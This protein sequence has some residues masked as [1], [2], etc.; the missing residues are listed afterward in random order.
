MILARSKD[1]LT[2]IKRFEKQQNGNKTKWTD[3][4]D[5]QGRHLTITEEGTIHIFEEVEDLP[6]LGGTFTKKPK[7]KLTKQLWLATD[8]FMP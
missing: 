2:V 4:K 1:E 5:I 3:K 7:K 6:Y 8:M